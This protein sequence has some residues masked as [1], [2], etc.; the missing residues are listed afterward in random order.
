MRVTASTFYKDYAKSVQDLKY[1]YNKSM[2]QVSS[3]KK[4]ENAYENPLDYYAGKKIDNLYNDVTTKSTMIKDVINRLEQQETTSRT[5]YSEMGDLN[6]KF[7]QMASA[8]YQ[9]K[10]DTVDTMYTYVLNKQQTLTQ[11]L[12]ATYENYF[13]MGGNDQTTV[14]FT[15]SADGMELTYHHKFPG[16]SYETTMTM[17]Y[18]PDNKS[19]NY[20]GTYYETTTDQ[21]TGR[22]IATQKTF[23]TE[24]EVL[25]KILQAMKEQGRMS[26]GYGDINTLE[27][28]PDTYYGG[29][30]MVT[31]LT[32]DKLRSMDPEKAKIAI[33]DAMNTSAFGLNAQVIDSTQKYRDSFYETTV[34]ESYATLD[35]KIEDTNIPL[36]SEGKLKIYYSNGSGYWFTN[37]KTISDIAS[38]YLDFTCQYD[39]N[40]GKLIFTSNTVG[41]DSAID[42][43]QET[44]DSLGLTFTPGTA[45]TPAYYTSMPITT[46]S[47][48]ANIVERPMTDE[49]KESAKES[50]LQK[51]N[52]DLNYAIGKWDNAMISVSNTFRRIGVATGTLEEVDNQLQTAEDTYIKEYNDHMAID[53]YDAIV[54]M[55][56][57][58]YSYNAAMQVGSKIMQNS[59]F[60]FVQ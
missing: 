11:D 49:E 14:P 20:S 38:T 44:I 12:N 9:G 2:Q 25:D 3:G 30:N 17:K 15:M 28:L 37:Q 7:E 26:L 16:D 21:T 31:G 4:Y 53:T 51:L 5:F 48:T 35:T 58:M 43:S 42:F 39:E 57:H 54:Q 50:A 47:E 34:T 60:D 23:N 18:D 22:V 10:V 29:L 1:I 24:D 8:S 56:Q 40:S 36:D 55:Y 6:V 32:S 19:F 41:T 13:V 52:E 27:T 33:Q 45:T 59:L 46:T